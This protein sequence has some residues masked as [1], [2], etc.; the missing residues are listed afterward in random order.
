MIEGDARDERTLTCSLVGTGAES[1]RLMHDPKA[2]S[3]MQRV[4]FR[5]YKN[6][7]VPE[8]FEPLNHKK[9]DRF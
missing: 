9:E 6:R 1:P 8:R 4:D 5:P 3:P 2:V 7:L